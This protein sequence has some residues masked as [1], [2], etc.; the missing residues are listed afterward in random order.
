[1]SD[2]GGNYV[3]VWVMGVMVGMAGIALLWVLS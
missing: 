1:M 3:I 2:C